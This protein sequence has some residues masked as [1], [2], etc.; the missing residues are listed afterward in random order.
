M[1]LMSRL[2]KLLSDNGFAKAV[3]TLVSGSLIAQALTIAVSPLLTRIFSPK[4]LGVY[5]LIL[6]AESLFGSIICGR[7]DVSIVSEPNEEKVY[8]IIKL[9]LIVTL[10]FSFLAAL[11]YGSFY[12]IFNEEY[13]GY[14]YAILFI[15]LM[16][17]FNGLMRILE[18]YN[19]RYKEYKLMTSVFVLKT[20]M[21]NLGS[22]V[23]GLLNFGV[24]GLLVSHTGGMLFGLKKQST[25]L[26]KHMKIVFSSSR[27][28]MKEVAMNHIRLPL[29]SAPAMFANRFS[30]ASIALGIEALY[31]LG[32]LGL[33]SISYKALGLPLTVMS[34]NVAKV[35]Y[36]EASREYDKTGKFI[37]SFKKTAMLLALIAI[38]MVLILYFLSP[39]VFEIVFGKEWRQAGIYVQFLAPMFG[40][41]LIV[42]TVAYGLQVVKKQHLEL[43]LQILF[44]VA[45]F[46]CFIISK[47]LKF[48]VTQ[49]LI[50]I[51]ISFSII[52]I[53]YF[54]T[55][56]LNA[57]GKL[58]NR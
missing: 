35:F 28:E 47:L 16:L 21:Q 17:V 58:K 49:Y 14:S 33:Y 42:N 53:L 11:G 30:Y 18:S 36:Q 45:S 39:L 7:Y 41:R 55:V 22:V 10:I 43:I 57:S 40:I 12:F 1:L 6:T 44:I 38:P 26:K 56:M 50:S 52:Y 4:E 19:N 34:N 51:S 32:V 31:G 46:T 15:F 25:K 29:Y 8:P 24:L 9:S 5:T 23:L 37:K 13:T 20:S 27:L 2:K 3:I 54:F 48:N